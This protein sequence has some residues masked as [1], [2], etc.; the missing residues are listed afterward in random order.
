[1][2]V[3]LRTEALEAYF[4]TLHVLDTYASVNYLAMYLIS[5]ARTGKG[6]SQYFQRLG[7]GIVSP[8][9]MTFLVYTYIFL[10]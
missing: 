8:S 1:M 4:K 5:H 6:Y 2:L 10:W 9:F 3:V 7:T